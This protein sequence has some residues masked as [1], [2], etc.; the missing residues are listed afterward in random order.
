M[1]FNK[2]IV[3]RRRLSNF[4]SPLQES[5]KALLEMRIT[6]KEKETQ[7]L[8]AGEQDPCSC[9]IEVCD[10]CNILFFVKASY[11]QHVSAIVLP[12]PLV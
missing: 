5:M 9:Y 6:S 11:I 10:I 3:N 8:L 7:A 4:D 2:V 12:F 1:Y